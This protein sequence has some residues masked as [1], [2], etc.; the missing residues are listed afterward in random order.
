MPYR[1]PALSVS[2]RREL[3]QTAPGFDWGALGDVILAG[4]G[5]AGLIYA[6]KILPSPFDTVATVAGIGLAGYAA[7]S[8]V[9]SI[10]KKAAVKNPNEVSPNESFRA[11]SPKEFADVTGAFLD[12][13]PGNVS[14]FNTFSDKYTVKVLVTNPSIEKVTVTFQL[15]VKESLYNFW[16]IPLG[17]FG[18]YTADTKT[19]NLPSGNT[20]FDFDSAAVKST[21]WLVGKVKLDLTLRKLRIAGGAAADSMDIAHTTVTLLG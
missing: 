14:G 3:G 13:S 5:G 20:P 12:P 8:L 16:V 19:M 9:G 21:R 7:Y 18:P 2:R 1:A 15:V 11:A 17:T 6:S 4:S 10:G